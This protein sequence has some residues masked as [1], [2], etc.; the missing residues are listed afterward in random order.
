MTLVDVSRAGAAET[1]TEGRRRQ[2]LWRL[3]SEGREWVKA[4]QSY[5]T[6]L[7]GRLPNPEI[8]R[9][10][11]KSDL[12]AIAVLL[13][14]QSG[15]DGF[16]PRERVIAEAYRLFPEQFGLGRYPGWPDAAKIDRAL[17]EATCLKCSGDTVRVLPEKLDEVSALQQTLHAATTSWNKGRH[18][19][20]RGSAHKAIAHVEKSLLY[21][22]YTSLG[23]EAAITE[24]DVSSLLSLTLE[25]TPELIQTR[26]TT[27]E[28]LLDQQERADLVRFLRWVYS[29]CEGRGWNLVEETESGR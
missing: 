5:L 13:S 7:R 4:N 11:S 9:Q 26:F 29:W 8:V 6:A 24:S 23:D 27:L 28:E 16:V 18:R 3:T 15:R 22:R 12:V 1:L 10:Q 25:A 2:K 20:I 21:P 17:S 19:Q 14:S